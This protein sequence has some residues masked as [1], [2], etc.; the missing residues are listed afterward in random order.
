MRAA[1]PVAASAA[2][3]VLVLTGCSQSGKT[4]PGSAASAGSASAPTTAANGELAVPQDA[5]EET[6]KQYL[7][8]NALAACMREKGFTYTPRVESAEAER[9]PF[10]GQDYELAK[11]YRAKY[12]YGV[13]YARVVYP[14]DVNAIGSR[15]YT[16]KYETSPDQEYRD[17]LSPAQQRAYEK[18]FGEL[19]L[20]DGKKTELPGCRK[21]AELRAYGPE[22]SE[23]E[24]AREA[25]AARAADRAAQQALDGDPQLVSLAQ[26]FAS[27]L[28]D[29]GITVTTTQPTS[30]GDMVKF[31]VNGQGENVDKL[32]KET[33]RAK[34]AQEIN[35]ALADL[36]CG[37]E[38][39]AAYFPKL[40]KHPFV[41]VGG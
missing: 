31:A 20:V 10:D 1:L 16:E 12:G 23:A 8:Q 15:A 18:A 32:N 7:Y 13:T 28:R 11:E 36:E 29:E 39:R 25:D 21:D 4:S 41:G 40:A 37:K 26:D 33:A 34:L 38:F 3:C 2:T 27:C 22:K 24:R 9:F 17:S 14:N 35:V 6:K 5:D 30:I 19:V